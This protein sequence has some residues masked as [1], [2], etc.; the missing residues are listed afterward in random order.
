[1]RRALLGLRSLA[2]VICLIIVVA[3]IAVHTSPVRRFAN[4][5]IVA[6][7]AR[8]Q[9]EFSTDELSYNVL[10]ASVNLRNIRIRSTAWPDAPVF[11][12]IGRARI[13]LGLVHLLR[14]RYVV[15]SGTLDDVDV[16]YVVD[17]QG[18]DNLPRPPKDPDAPS[19]P[20]DYLVSSLTI[21]KANVRYENRAQQI[22]AR[23][24]FSSIEVN[25]NALTDRHQIAFNATGGS[26]QIQERHAAV[27]R[28]AGRV[29]LGKD[30]VSIERL[31]VD[32]VGS[33]A[34]VSGTI[35]QF[36]SPMADL[37]VTSDVNVMGVAPL[38][39]IQDPVSGVVTID[40]TAKGPLSTPA[41]NAH[42]SGSALQFRD[43]RDVQLDAT[44]AYDL[45]TRHAD[46]SSLRVSG[47]W[48]G[49]TGN[50]SVTLDGSAQSAMHAD[51]D[52]VDAGAVMRALDLPYVAAT[53][54]D[55]KVEAE[56][57]GLDYL[58]ARGTADAR[59]RPTASET[60]RSAMPLGGRLIAR[61]DGRRIDV[62]LVQVSVP[63]GEVNGTVAVTG[64]RQLQGEINGRSS[65]VEQVVSS[66][67]A[68][69]GQPKGSLLPTPVAGA[70]EITARLAGSLSAPTA[71][72]T[73]TAPAL[74]V[75]TTEGIAV[76]AEAS[77]APRAL[78]VARADVTW[79]QARA[80]LDGRVGLG[81][82][83]SI[84]L[85]VSADDLDAAS[86]LQA[87]NTAGAPIT[88]MF[89]A[90][91]TVT[92]TT[93]RPI[94]MITVQGSNL[95][96]Y[97]EEIGSLN[98]DVRLDGRQLTVS[99]VV[100]DKPQPDQPGR[101]TATGTYDL[102]GKTYT[103]DL[104]SQSVRLV[105]LL[106]PDGRRV[107]G[108]V[109]RLAARGAGTIDSPAGSV[110]LDVESLEIDD[111]Q[112]GRLV[113]NAVAKN[114]E[115]TITASAEHFNLDADALIGLTRPWPATVKLRAADLDLATLPLQ[116]TP[117]A[118]SAHLAT[119]P[120]SDPATQRPND[121]ATQ[122]PGNPAT[123][124]PRM[125]GL[126]GH[127]RATVD[128]SGTLAEP[129]KGRATVALE[130]LEGQWNGR[131][132]TLTSPS[133]IQ[134]AGERLTVEQLHVAASDASLTVS[135]DLPLTNGA[136]PGE[137]AIDL[138]GNLATVTQYLPP[139]TNIAGDGAIAL[140]GSLRGTLE[141]IE[142]DLTL[143][144]DN[145][146]IL[147]PLFEPGF[148]NIV[149]RA[150]IENGE[151]DIDQL[152][153]NWGTATLQGSGRIP[154]EA[155][156]QL[157][158]DIP[159]MSG[160]ATF[161]VGFE[162]LDPSAIPGAPPQLSGRV[163]AT[164]EM[165][166]ARVDPSALNGQ[167]T[168]QELDVAFSGLGLA[169]QQP[170]TITIASGAATVDR[171]ELSGS[172]GEI[173]AS[174]SVG[175]VED[176]AL[177]V[178]VDGTL[179]VA[180]LSLLTDQIRAEGESALKLTARGTLAN[181]DVTGTVDVM[182]ATAVSDEP[183]VAAENINAH[184]D[185]EGRRITLAQL[186]ADVN[187]GTLEGSGSITLGAGTLSGVNLEISGKNIAYDAPLD[188]RSITDST[189]TVTKSGEDIL[190]AGKVTI[191]EAG[192]TGDINFD[193]GLLASM[194]AR[195]RLDLTEERNPI[196]ERVRFNIAVDTAMPV[197]VD[198]NLARAEIE[199]DLTV[200]GTPY[201]TGLL[202]ELTVLE[203]SEIRLNERR[204]ETERGVITFA[205][206]RRIFPTF[207]LRLNTTA[208]AYDITIAVTGTPGDTQTTLTS[209][210][211]LPEPDIMAMLVHRPHPRR[212]AWRRVRSRS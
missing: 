158:V 128:A 133:P 61:G 120:P 182:H 88:G 85:S 173:H 181:P 135:G 5:R 107:R 160:P 86:L 66:I 39:D 125:A 35:T 122:P 144:L 51:I 138:H 104:Q 27:D 55:G 188:L 113:I 14:G 147:S 191:D 83:Q 17:E 131:P 97:E 149:L 155:L 24:P 40:A 60:S 157:P 6:L 202:G 110:D 2:A 47:P 12:T 111:V 130:S 197:V 115:A 112:A 178:N 44:A 192:L 203:G 53:R 33:H 190:V 151:A 57:P 20:L 179:Q 81:P 99:E 45:V 156:P 142:P 1:M 167:I 11:A 163:S 87:M 126:Q 162:G 21:A 98:A 121:P 15:E 174:G 59:L 43:L 170:S 7:L 139:E 78:T 102:D 195:R 152:A 169:Q 186:A 119:Q 25:G 76:N 201:E 200:V 49:V 101:I 118:E 38:A 18:R 193:T 210:P 208:G 166:A 22:D 89:R 145:G 189:I 164:A 159:R 129:E 177:N 64:D 211:T 171:L 209:D 19:Q 50:G 114:N 95:V 71:A 96:A 143:T 75:G 123:Q 69:T 106:L 82:D 94:A 62:Q 63:G 140:T 46:V 212:H 175:L 116:A 161:K 77:Y 58:H 180:A 68:F 9:I 184:F 185:L 74:T 93:A 34:E 124:A 194:T 73:I 91:G 37:S 207:D 84:A 154:L 80:H 90:R 32:T 26:L 165:T 148:S 206:E 196:L 72:T 13:N 136:T 28:M 31:E 108:D 150:R 48:G 117:G 132:F 10:N 187:G 168:F 204:Y 3:L 127:L 105:G 92:G 109:K 183:N 36:D 100:V 198:N 52:G 42:L 205:D 134:Y 79:Q 146:L 65:S 4:D 8:E 199:A 23:L 153:A 176:R 56:W 70:A 30:D 41:I 172:A 16:H 29:D 67:E 137:I 103:F 141:R 54:V